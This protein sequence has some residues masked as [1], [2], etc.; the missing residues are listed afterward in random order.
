[1]RSNFKKPQK[2]LKGLI[3]FVKEYLL[4][5]GCEFL[6]TEADKS[7]SIIRLLFKT[8]LQKLFRQENYGLPLIV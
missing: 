4:R 7:I 1:M 3:R 8:Y 5:Y 2:D 6:C